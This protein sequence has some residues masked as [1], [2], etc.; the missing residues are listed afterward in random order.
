M[1]MNTVWPIHTME[2]S[3]AL[4]SKAVLKAMLTHATTRMNP[5]DTVLNQRSQTETNT[6]TIPL[7]QVPGAVKSGDRQ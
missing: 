3:S 4:K 1:L 2:H 7:G 6:A 5:E